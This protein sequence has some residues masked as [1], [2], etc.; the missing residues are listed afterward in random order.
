MGEGRRGALLIARSES[1][2]ESPGGSPG[3]EASPG[4]GPVRGRTATAARGRRG[5]R[6]IGPRPA[7]GA[8]MPGEQGGAA[9][10]GASAGKRRRGKGPGRRAPVRNRARLALASRRHSHR[11]SAPRHSHP[12]RGVDRVSHSETAD[13]RGR[14]GTGAPG[15]QWPEV[16]DLCLL[17]AFSTRATCDK[18]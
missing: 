13:Q 3:R 14:R 1:P 18:I 11:A 4:S 2:A 9:R 5:R 12:R 16:S 6:M 8:A 7:G 10:R 15:R 17:T